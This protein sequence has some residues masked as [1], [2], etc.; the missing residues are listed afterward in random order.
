MVKLGPIVLKSN[1]ILFWLTLKPYSFDLEITNLPPVP[2]GKQYQ[3][4][5]IVDGTPVD[6]GVFDV[7]IGPENFM[8]VQHIE[9]PQAFA[10]TVE[11]EGGSPTPTLEEMV[12]IGNVS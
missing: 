9:N 10:V 2:T 4:W 11:N 8:E 7:S 1:D 12:V 5:A 3:L 6:M